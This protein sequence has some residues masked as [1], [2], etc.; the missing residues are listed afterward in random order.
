MW[1]ESTTDNIKQTSPLRDI[2]L[3]KFSTLYFTD[4]SI[5]EQLK[6]MEH[7]M[8]IQLVIFWLDTL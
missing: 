1:G 2:I 4:G 6:V 3:G 8:D 7:S 5:R